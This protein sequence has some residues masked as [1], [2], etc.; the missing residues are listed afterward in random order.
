V[1]LTSGPKYKEFL[2]KIT[3]KPTKN[4]NYNLTAPETKYKNSTRLKLTIPS[5]SMNSDI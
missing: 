2:L 1:G 5:L 3:K 4:P